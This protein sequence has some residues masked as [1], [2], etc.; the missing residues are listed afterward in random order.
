MSENRETSRRWTMIASWIWTGRLLPRACDPRRPLRRP[1]VRRRQ[2]HR[3]L[4]PADLPGAHAEAR[5]RALL[6]HRRGGAGGRLPALPAL[7]AGDL[8]RPRR[9]ARH[10]QHRVPRARPDRGRRARRRRR[11]GPGRPAGRRRAAAAAAVPPASRRLADRRR[12]D[13]ARAAGQAA[14]PRDP[15]A[16]D[17]G[18]AGRRASAAC[19]ASTRPSSSCYGRPPAALRRAGGADESRPAT[20][21]PYGQPAPIG[22]PTTGTRMLGFLRA[23]RHPRRRDGV[24]R[25]LSPARIA[26]GG[27]A[28]RRSASSRRAA[29]PRGRPSASR[30]SRPCRRSS[31][32]CGGCSTWPPTRS[33]SARIWPGPGAGAAGRRAAGPAGARRLGRLRAG[34]ARH[35]RPADHRS[36]GDA[37]R[38]QAGARAIGARAAGEPSIGAEASHRVFPTPAALAGGRSRRARHAGPRRRGAVRAGRGGRRRSRTSS[39]AARSL[40]EAVAQLRALPGIGEWTAQYIA[41]RELREP[42]AFPA[43]D[44]GLMRAMADATARRPTPA[45]LLARAEAWRPWRAYAALHLWAADIAHLPSH[46]GRSHDRQAA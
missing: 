30:S 27:D 3:H 33:R 9:L 15:A 23:A 6:S 18:R 39:A 26:I 40:D 42:D 19:A 22:R 32:G 12:A 45:A 17:R 37:A 28:R 13:P 14:D 21:R 44:I 2:D 7:P 24:G 41:M 31:P 36:G 20:A 25:P 5:E 1:A 29:T 8:A 4:L 43:A 35:P 11:R 16:D 46:R 10:L 38:R 34:G